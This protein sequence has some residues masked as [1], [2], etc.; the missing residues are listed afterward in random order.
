MLIKEEDTIF[1]A[2]MFRLKGYGGVLIL[3]E[4]FPRKIQEVYLSWEKK[5]AED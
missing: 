3:Q 4:G 1:P 5:L 2:K